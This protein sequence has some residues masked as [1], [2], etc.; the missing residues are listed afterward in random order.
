MELR[1]VL[2]SQDVNEIRAKTEALQ[3]AA[4]KLAE[5]LYAQAAQQA[6]PSNGAASSDDEVVE[7]ADYEVIDEE[8]GAARS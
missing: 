8:E 2:D 1:G 4:T 5:V 3:E 7:D 6:G